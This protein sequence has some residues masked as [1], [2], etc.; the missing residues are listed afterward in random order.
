MRNNSIV[1]RGI[2]VYISGA[3][4]GD[5][6]KNIETARKA[7]IQI[8]EA[9][10]SFFCPHLNTAHFEKD[11]KL[12]YEDYLAMDLEIL[13][14]CD[15]LVYLPNAENS[16]GSKKEQKFAE[17]MGIPCFPIEEFLKESNL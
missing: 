3:Y 2:L 8:A 10:Y 12:T 14:R 17:S 6:D 1:D 7:S 13:S 15:V 4:T 11:C 16:D 9:G 5:I